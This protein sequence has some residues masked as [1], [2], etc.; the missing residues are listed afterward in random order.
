[1]SL[2]RRGPSHIRPLEWLRVLTMLLVPVL[3]GCGAG[4]RTAPATT[5]PNTATL[6]TQPSRAFWRGDQVWVSLNSGTPIQVTHISYP[7]SAAG[8]AVPIPGTLRWSPGG[9]YLAFSYTLDTLDTLASNVEGMPALARLGVIDTMTGSVTYPEMPTLPLPVAGVAAPLAVN[10]WARGGYGWSDVTML[11][12]AGFPRA[13]GGAELLAGLTTVYT[14]DA[15]SGAASPVAGLQRLHLGALEVRAHTLFYSAYLA[16]PGATGAHAATLHRFDVVGNTDTTL[17]ALGAVG[18]LP[19]SSGEPLVGAFDISATGATMAYQRI[20]A[21]DA[22]GAAPALSATYVVA[23][24]DGTRPQAVLTGL[25]ADHHATPVE[26]AL[27]PDGSRVAA[28]TPT[29]VAIDDAAG[30]NYQVLTPLDTSAA[31]TYRHIAWNPDS[32]SFTMDRVAGA[33]DAWRIFSI[34][35][36]YALYLPHATLLAWWPAATGVV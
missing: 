16:D 29:L 9:R 26:L 11:V 32:S 31:V 28:A 33:P 6:L 21:F 20:D 23:G 2:S 36:L 27:A 34:Q 13:Q 7:A 3:A 14:V 19:G 30:T 18:T 5:L 4:P 24:T 10:I 12:V 1:M 22:T 8:E 15:T 17:V 25:A 35:P